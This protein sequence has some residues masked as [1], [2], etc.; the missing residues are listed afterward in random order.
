[1]TSDSGGE[2]VD[3]CGVAAEST[4][5]SGLVSV[6]AAGP[7]QA[8]QQA[9]PTVNLLRQPESA[10]WKP[11][12]SLQSPKWNFQLAN[13]A[14]SS[15]FRK[16]PPGIK[17]KLGVAEC[18]FE[19]FTVDIGDRNADQQFRRGIDDVDRRLPDGTASRLTKSKE[20]SMQPIGTFQE[21]ARLRPH[22]LPGTI[23]I[24]VNC[25]SVASFVAGN[26]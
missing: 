24:H 19:I 3:S 1:M 21:L 9:A 7:H 16:A 20:H 5:L 14:A 11:D 15:R 17:E 18:N 2:A 23:T 22:E 25:T 13:G 12:S 26:M 8:N 6:I 10:T 4:M